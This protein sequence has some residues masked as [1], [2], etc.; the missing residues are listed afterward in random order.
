MANKKNHAVV[1]S[2][3]AHLRS[4]IGYYGPLENELS[5]TAASLAPFPTRPSFFREMLGKHLGNAS[6]VS[7]P[8]LDDTTPLSSLPFILAKQT[9]W[10][11]ACSNGSL[12]P[13][14]CAVR[15]PQMWRF[16][17]VRYCS[18]DAVTSL[19]LHEDATEL[20]LLQFHPG[21]PDSL[22]RRS[23]FQATC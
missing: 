9:F 10:L 6:F 14:S 2:K 5:K 4:M 22:I 23:A 8:N 19:A 17:L 1:F 12:L 21:L 3:K 16:E 18:I 20:R 13:R 11:A 15:S 7:L